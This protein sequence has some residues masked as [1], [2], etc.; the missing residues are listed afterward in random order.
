MFQLFFY[1]ANAFVNAFIVSSN[2]KVRSLKKR[3]FAFIELG[4]KK[5]VLFPFNKSIYYEHDYSYRNLLFLFI[6]NLVAIMFVCDVLDKI[7]GFNNKQTRM[8]FLNK[9]MFY[10]R[11]L[12]GFR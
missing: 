3:Y 2:D 4:V 5:V 8:R 9:C 6:N 1:Y 10:F 7:P 11:F 12:G